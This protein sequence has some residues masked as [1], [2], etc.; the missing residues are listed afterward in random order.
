MDSI[1]APG[2]MEYI[3][4]KKP[5]GCIF[6]L[7]PA[8][9][10]DLVLYEGK[11]CYIMM[12]KYPYTSGHLLV[13]PF[14]HICGM[15]ETNDEEKIEMMKLVDMCVRALK[16]ALAPEGFNIGLNL[17]KAAGAGVDDHLHIHIVP[18]WLG[19]TNFATVLGE[20]RVIPEDIAKT[21]NTLLPYFPG[22]EE[23]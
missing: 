15:E 13:I 12:N 23:M 17:G 4:G 3:R 22:R 5:N 14:R 16:K 18:R 1:M 10:E 2:R 19:D 6:C 20:V 7:G 11:S 8:R 21:R 9:D